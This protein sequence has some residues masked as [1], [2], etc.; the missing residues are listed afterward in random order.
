MSRRGAGERPPCSGLSGAHNR[1]QGICRAHR[2]KIV[3]SR[4][5][6]T[7]YIVGT[8]GMFIHTSCD[9]SSDGGR[10][11]R[12]G[13]CPIPCLSMNQK[14][15]KSQK[16]IKQTPKNVFSIAIKAISVSTDHNRFLSGHEQAREVA[17]PC[18]TLQKVMSRRGADERPPC[19]WLSGTNTIGIRESA[20]HTEKQPYLPRSKIITT[21]Y[22]VGTGGMF[23]HPSCDSSPG[24][25]RS[26][27]E[28]ACP[29]P[30]L[31]MNRKTQKISENNQTD[32]QECFFNRYKGHFCFYR[33]Q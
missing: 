16:T 18:Q 20:E 26:G 29:I 31:F 22:T 9:P 32:T 13:A 11:G 8:G 24:G 4:I 7:P 10:S 1:N 3:F 19:S 17:T 33:S 5:C 28:G 23:T 30:C 15:K 12:E 25:G 6:T 14:H 21:P 2:I 27:R